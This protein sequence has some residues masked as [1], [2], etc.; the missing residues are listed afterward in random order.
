M[1][2]AQNMEQNCPANWNGINYT[3]SIMVECSNGM[4]SVKEESGNCVPQT[5]PQTTVTDAQSGE[6]VILPLTNNGMT[7]TVSCDQGFTGEISALCSNGAW[8]NQ[9]G[10]CTFADKWVGICVD[11]GQNNNPPFESPPNYSSGSKTKNQCMNDCEGED[12]CVAYSY[13]QDASRC[14]LWVDKLIATCPNKPGYSKHRGTSG[15]MVGI[16]EITRGSGD[17]GWICVK[18][19]VVVPDETYDKYTN[20]GTGMGLCANANG[21]SPS[22]YS[23]NFVEGQDSTNYCEE[24]CE[25]TNRC[26]GYSVHTQNDKLNRCAIWV[27]TMVNDMEEKPVSG[28]GSVTGWGKF[29]AETG[30]NYGSDYI[31][32]HD[33]GNDGWTCYIRESMVLLAETIQCNNMSGVVAVMD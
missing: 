28:Q 16:S 1:T 23:K 20:Q 12:L 6:Q 3:G 22:N 18:K 13:H 32:D 33:N 5:C 27:D 9:Q 4:T 25:K 7:A 14:A 21:L 8:T 10:A 24:E 11:G 31:S 26:Q 15:W 19:E 29:A 17:A 2:E 30:W